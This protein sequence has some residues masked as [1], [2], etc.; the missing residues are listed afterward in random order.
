MRWN[1]DSASPPGVDSAESRLPDSRG[2]FVWPARVGDHSSPPGSEPSLPGSS[3]GSLS[4][5]VVG[6][7]TGEEAIVVQRTAFETEGGPRELDSLA[8]SRTRTL[9]A[10]AFL[11]R[12][13]QSAGAVRL[14]S[15]GEERLRGKT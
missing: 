15:S 9:P 6:I 11:L 4:R 5:N 3:A 13:S 14:P 12:S 10:A 8:E 1:V 2:C 7:V